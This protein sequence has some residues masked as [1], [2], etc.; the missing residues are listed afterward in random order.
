MKLGYIGL[1]KMGKNMVLRLLEQGLEVVAWN[2]S[3]SRRK[4]RRC[5]WLTS[6]AELVQ[7]LP[8]P[9]ATMVP[10]GALSMKCCLLST[11]FSR[12]FSYR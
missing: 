9:R 3:P 1:G 12:R 7:A 10:N 4:L 2:R 8:A 11:S 6:I 5:Y